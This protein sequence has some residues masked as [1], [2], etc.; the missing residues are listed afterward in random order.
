MVVRAIGRRTPPLRG[1]H[2]W[3]IIRRWESA[4]QPTPPPSHHKRRVLVSYAEVFDCA[5][6]VE[7]GTFLGDT[8]AV[9]RRYAERVYSIELDDELAMRAKGRFRNCD[10]VQI[11][12]GDSA[13]E[14][15]RLLSAIPRQPSL[16]WLDGHF[17][18]GITALGGEET[19]I[20]RELAA[21]LPLPA[22]RAVLID[23]AREFGS[24]VNYPVL[25][26]I[27][28]LAGQYGFLFEVRDDIIRL[29]RW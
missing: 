8:V 24:N 14:L 26:T 18:G 16:F 3:W 25:E 9:M 20:M 27:E 29:I 17:S 6:F 21:V 19:P 2:R 13:E 5:T 11:I 23:D 22:A 28:R 7:T 4:G 1:L 15:P 10:N 12:Q